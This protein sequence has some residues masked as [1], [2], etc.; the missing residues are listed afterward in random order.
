[1]STYI[2]DSELCRFYELLLK[3]RNG[4]I[5]GD[6]EAEF[7]LLR[8]KYEELP[9]QRLLEDYLKERSPE[10]KQILAFSKIK[11]RLSLED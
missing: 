10:I 11:S 4:D 6:E 5:E 8:I 1:M 9:Y 7:N 2:S 3:N